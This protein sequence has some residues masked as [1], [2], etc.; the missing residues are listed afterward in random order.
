L[1]FGADWDGNGR[2]WFSHW[3]HP[4]LL[5]QLHF[6]GLGIPSERTLE[7][8]KLANDFVFLRRTGPV[9]EEL[10]PAEFFVE[11]LRS[12]EWGLRV[13]EELKQPQYRIY[14]RTLA[15]ILREAAEPPPSPP[16]Y[17]TVRG[18]E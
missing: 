4:A 10:A 11:Q 18:H 13:P 5:V 12:E 15:W 7:E 3:E 9:P 2:I 14:L 6:F 16:P 8:L 1:S 17:E